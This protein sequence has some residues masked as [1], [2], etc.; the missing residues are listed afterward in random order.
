MLQQ[1][2]VFR[3]TSSGAD[4]RALWAYRYRVG[5]RG[6]KRVQRGG[7]ASKQ[8]AGEA[9]E[10]A[11]ER[12]RRANSTATTLTLAELIDEYLAQHDAQPETIEKLRWLLAKAVRAF[13]DR[14]IGELRSQEIA[15]WRMTIPPGHRFEATQALRQVLT[16]AVEWGMIDV[17]P[18]K[19]GVNNPQR[20]RTEKRPFESWAQLADVAARLGP[21]CRP[22]VMFAAATGLRPG[23]WI[24]LEHRDID[25]EARVVYVRRAFR[26][27][28]LK[29]T[30][31]EGSVRAVPLQAVALQALEQVPVGGE[32]D[33]LFPSSRGGYFDLHNF[34]TRDWKPAQIAAEIT[35]LRRV[36]DL[37]HT[38]ATFALRAGISTFDLSRYMGASLTMIDRHYG[39]LARDGRD[40]AIK[41]LDTFTSSDTTNVHAVDAAWTLQPST[42]AQQENRKLT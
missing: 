5:G 42:V 13:G 4:G 6:S 28:R 31:T 14:R 30:K 27:G 10:R 2:Q 9:L 12:L 32:S 11:L 20:R 41:L 37:R 16:R 40:H 39:H 33:L 38:F 3:L 26:N 19:Q 21:G 25:R 29:C 17:N 18:A 22:L 1:G 24:A 23:E 35:P 36:Y 7:F 34:R 15:V 8:D